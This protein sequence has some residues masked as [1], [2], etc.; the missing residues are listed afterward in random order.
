MVEDALVGL[1]ADKKAT[2]AAI[3]KLLG[4][5]IARLPAGVTLEEV[6]TGDLDQFS[7]INSGQRYMLDIRI[8]LRL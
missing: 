6:E 4:D 7:I 3:A 2:E 8:K 1:L 5:F